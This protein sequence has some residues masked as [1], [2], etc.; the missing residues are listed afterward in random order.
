MERPPRFFSS[1]ACTASPAFLVTFPEGAAEI[2]SCLESHSRALRVV[3]NST[4]MYLLW[5]AEFLC[6]HIFYPLQED[7]D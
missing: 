7:S 5:A 2:L 3:M 1:Y 6:M 4:Y